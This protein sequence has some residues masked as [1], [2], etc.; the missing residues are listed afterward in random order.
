[1]NIEKLKGMSGLSLLRLTA[2][3]TRFAGFWFSGTTITMQEMGMHECFMY[4]YLEAFSF[5]LHNICE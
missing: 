2:L 4:E 5:S 1:M 3:I